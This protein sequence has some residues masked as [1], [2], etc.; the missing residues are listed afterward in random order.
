MSKNLGIPYTDKE[1]Y[2]FLSYN[3]EDEKRVAEYAKAL[4]ELGVPLWY[5]MGIKIGTEW[6]NEIA[7]RID[8]C[9]SVIM[10]LSRNIFLKDTSYVH[11][12][13][14]LATEYSEKTVYIVMLDEIRKPEAPIH[15]RGWWTKVTRLQCLNAYEYPT[16]MDAMK[17]FAD[18]I[19]FE[20]NEVV[21]TEL[22]EEPLSEGGLNGYGKRTDFNGNIYEGTFV[23]DELHG[24]GKI[25]FVR[26]GQVW[27]GDF[28]N[29]ALTGKGKITFADGEISEGDF[30]DGRLNGRG[31]NTTVDGY[32]FDG[33]FK[34]DEMIDGRM[35]DPDGS[36][37]EGRFVDGELNGNGRMV[38]DDGVSYEGEF[39]D[40]EPNGKGRMVFAD[41]TL[42]E[43][44]V[45]DGEPNGMGKITTTD[46]T[47]MESTFVN[48]LPEGKGKII[49]PDGT[50]YEATFADGELNGKG[51]VIYTDGTVEEGSFVDGVFVG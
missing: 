46:G 48:G 41:G 14:E 2:Y 45:S 32:V 13:Y 15:F 16:V 7:Y 18:D 43:G 3:S 12:E 11:K 10:F 5:D 29:G 47:T 49:F 44:Y 21:S 20:V 42:F 9:D 24:K 33:I 38:F 40:G 36:I 51:R 30:I 27:E 22:T 4:A 28:V 8:S 25:T 35:T 39:V 6:E 19:G 34:D 1:P 37:F 26:L 50:V 23:N 31:K 17:K